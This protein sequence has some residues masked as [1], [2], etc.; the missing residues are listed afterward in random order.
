MRLH[1]IT[2]QDILVIWDDSTVGSRCLLTYAVEFSSTGDKSSYNRINKQDIIFTTFVHSMN[3]KQSK[4]LMTGADVSGSC[5]DK[6]RV[7]RDNMRHFNPLS[8]TGLLTLY[9]I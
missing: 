3:I 6:E 1:S 7:T 9:G 4:Y 2:S 8:T 5:I